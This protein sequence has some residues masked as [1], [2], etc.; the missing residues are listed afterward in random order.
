LDLHI[1]H[2]NYIILVIVDEMLTDYGVKRDQTFV[3]LRQQIYL[4]RC[5]N[6]KGEKW[7]VSAVSFSHLLTIRIKTRKKAQRMHSLP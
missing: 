4:S 2:E 5:D 6:P 3:N 1:F 7:P